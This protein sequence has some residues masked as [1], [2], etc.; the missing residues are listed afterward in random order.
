MIFVG[1]QAAKIC[2][3]CVVDAAM[4][5]NTCNSLSSYFCYQDFSC[6][7]LCCSH[8][9][10]KKILNIIIAENSYCMRKMLRRVPKGPWLCEECKFAE[11]TDNQK[12]GKAD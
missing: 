3:P 4:V 7:T 11:E 1:M 9:F 12:Q 2:L 10:D 8:A 6:D 5:Q